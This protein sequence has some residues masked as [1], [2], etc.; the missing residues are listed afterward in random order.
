M[1]FLK[2]STNRVGARAQETG[3]LV[4]QQ[5]GIKVRYDGVVDGDYV[6]DLLVQKEVCVEL[7][8][9]KALDNIHVAHYLNYLRA[10]RL[11]V[12]LLLNFGTP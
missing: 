5:K 8:A 7:K 3:F 11:K 10:T 12:C 9:V 1:A 6:A 4:G 2:G